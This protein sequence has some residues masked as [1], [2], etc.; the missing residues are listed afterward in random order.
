MARLGC[1]VINQLCWVSLAICMPSL[2][3]IG[4]A[5]S[6]ESSVTD[7]AERRSQWWSAER[8]GAAGASNTLTR[9][10]SAAGVFRFLTDL[11]R[12]L[13]SPIAS[14]R[15]RTSMGLEPVGTKRSGPSVAVSTV[16]LGPRRWA[17]TVAAS[18]ALPARQGGQALCPVG[19]GVAAP[20]GGDRSPGGGQAP[21]RQPMVRPA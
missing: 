3:H 12:P 20:L 19:G 2:G 17:I 14:V 4:D 21:D 10:R 5:F 8:S 18:A 15:E 13:T 11:R 7:C 1:S 9:K 16:R 6:T